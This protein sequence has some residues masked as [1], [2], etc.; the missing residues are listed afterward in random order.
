MTAP[1]AALP[2]HCSQVFPLGFPT[3]K[4]GDGIVVTCCMLVGQDAATLRSCAGT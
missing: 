3:H 2:Q 1:D 4:C